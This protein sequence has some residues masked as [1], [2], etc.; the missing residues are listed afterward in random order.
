M[1]PGET[2]MA[3]PRVNTWHFDA[4]HHSKGM[5]VLSIFRTEQASLLLQR[6]RACRLVQSYRSS[7]KVK[8][9]EDWDGQLVEG[10]RP[11]TVGT[12]ATPSSVTVKSIEAADYGRVR[13][14]VTVAPDAYSAGLLEGIRRAH[15]KHPSL[16]TYMPDPN[17]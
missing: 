14:A 11:E 8:P 17:V 16:V 7:E 1:N 12:G 5:F 4:R 3:T 2:F 15:A 10:L 9:G 6:L 13:Q